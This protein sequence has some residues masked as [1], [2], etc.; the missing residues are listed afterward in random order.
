[1][2]ALGK[3]L[4]ELGNCASRLTLGALTD[5]GRPS[6]PDAIP[7]VRSRS[8]NEHLL[9]FYE[10]DPSRRHHLHR[11]RNDPQVPCSDPAGRRTQRN[12]SGG[13]SCA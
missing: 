11:T 9:K 5:P 10:S 2:P 8:S 6:P 13:L 12:T 3:Y 4:D 7:V 1:M